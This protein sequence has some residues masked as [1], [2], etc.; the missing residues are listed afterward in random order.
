MFIDKVRVYVQ[1]G[2]GGNGCLSFRREKYIPLGGPNGGNGG[3]GG[4]I[5]FVA[6]ANL[7]T[8]LDI[9]YHPHI[10]AQDGNRGEAWD[11]HG[12][13]GLDLYVQVPCGTI[14]YNDGV[15]LGDLVQEKEPLLVAQGGRGGRGNSSFKTS[16]NVAP[17][18]AEKGEPGEN[19][20]LDLELKMLADVGLVGNP[21]A[22][23][24]TLLSR[25]TAARPKIADYPFTTLS[26]N[27]GVAQYKEKNFVVADIPGLI[28]G[29]HEGKGLGIDFLRHIER[30]RILVHLIDISG[31]DG[32][33]PLQCYRSIKKELALYSKKLAQKPCIIVA[34][35]MD[36]TGADVQLKKFKK[37]LKSKKV[38]AISA[39]TGAGLPTLF[40]EIVRVLERSPAQEPD[41]K[42]PALSP[43]AH[44]LFA[45]EFKVFR[46]EECFRVRG[47]KVE[48][49]INMT[50]FSQEEAVSRFQNILRAMG[51]ERQLQKLGVLPGDTVKISEYEFKYSLPDKN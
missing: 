38:W 20:T 10:R 39:V 7:K 37:S 24:S 23:K 31:F 47:K 36:C 28:S 40:T 34:N 49:L 5:I 21:N 16:R 26:P 33:S 6:N 35:K 42:E 9:S 17:K 1:A 41:V 14:I 12:R 3:R 25:I 27:L 29:A 46:E 15:K 8:L 45:D 4:S 50:N 32:K 18:I 44:Y 13:Y 30:T 2:A 48:R 51:V 11:K 43:H 19:F 22:G